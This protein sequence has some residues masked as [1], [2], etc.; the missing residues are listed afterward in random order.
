MVLTVVA[1]LLFSNFVL[2]NVNCYTKVD[3][4]NARFIGSIRLRHL[5]QEAVGSGFLCTTS[6]ISIQ[7][8]ITTA[9]CVTNFLVSQ[10][11]AVMGVVD[12]SSRNSRAVIRDI[13]RMHF[14]PAFNRSNESNEFYGN[15]AV[16]QFSYS[17]RH[18]TSRWAILEFNSNRNFH[19]Q[20]IRLSN[21]ILEE[22]LN[23]QYFSW[24]QESID[25]E[26]IS[27]LMMSLMS[28]E[29]DECK[30][31]N[32]TFCARNVNNQSLCSDT[33]GAL[34]FNSS[35][36][37]ISIRQSCIQITYFLEIKFYRDWITAVSAVS[38]TCSCN[39]NILILVFIKIAIKISS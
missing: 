10:L 39:I 25:S 12:I 37:G 32:F 13:R 36:Y 6:V 15:V 2:E 3:Q 11:Q 31:T 29:N 7:H 23:Y 27:N 21:F 20:P 33:G 14:H 9:T 24:K 8:A 28:I 35:L 1:L 22:S 19:V 30:N 34:V 4:R 26:R 16:V 17:I 38:R 5:E 18:S